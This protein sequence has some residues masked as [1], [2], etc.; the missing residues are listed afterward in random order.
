MSRSQSRRS[1][2]VEF[3]RGQGASA[4]PER[5]PALGACDQPPDVLVVAQDDEKGDADDHDARSPCRRPARQGRRPPA[6]RPMPRARSNGTRARRRAR[7]ARRRAPPARRARSRTPSAVATPLPPRNPSQTGN[8][9]P[10]TAQPPA[11]RAASA[12]Q[13]PPTTTAAA[14]F[15]R[16]SSR[17]SAASALAA[18]AQD[19][20]SAD[21]ARADPADVAMAG[22]AG[23]APARTGSSP[24]GSR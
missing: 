23:S 11:T 20:G 3:A 15:V 4:F 5:N 1:C 19:V 7:P 21:I 9:W 24:G 14:P 17:V 8:I 13:P 22:R 2:G 18:G 12:P 6:S 10:I 16:S